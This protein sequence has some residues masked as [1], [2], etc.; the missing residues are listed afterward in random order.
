[1]FCRTVWIAVL[2]LQIEILQHWRK[3]FLDVSCNK[4]LNSYS[5]RN[6]FCEFLKGKESR[7]KSFKNKVLETLFYP[8]SHECI[9]LWSFLGKGNPRELKYKSPLVRESKTVLDSVRIPDSCS[10]FQSLTVERGFWIPIVSVIPDFL[11][12]FTVSKAQDSGFHNKK[13]MDHL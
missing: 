12:C 4:I 5:H 6:S 13:K 11:S 9:F 8:N 1:M 3:R 2:R 7:P 10:G